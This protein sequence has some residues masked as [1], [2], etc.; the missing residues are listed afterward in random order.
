MIGVRVFYFLKCFCLVPSLTF[1]DLYVF[2]W[3]FDQLIDSSAPDY[4]AQQKIRITNVSSNTTLMGSMSGVYTQDFSTLKTKAGDLNNNSQFLVMNSVVNNPSG[5]NVIEFSATTLKFRTENAIVLYPSGGDHTDDARYTYDSVYELNPVSGE[6]EFTTL[7]ASNEQEKALAEASGFEVVLIE[8]QSGD[9][10]A[11]TSFKSYATNITNEGSVNIETA[12]GLITEQ[13]S[14]PDGT[15]L[16]RKEDDGTV[17]IGL[18]SIVLADEAVSASGTDEVYS[19]SGVLQLGNNG[20]HRTVIKGSLEVP[21]PTIGS[22]AANKSYVD[23]IGA[24]MMAA[25]QVTQTADPN[26]NL[27]IGFGLG[28]LAGENAL[29]L[30]LTGLSNDGSLRY[31]VTATYSDYAD[32]VAVGAGFSWSLR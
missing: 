14:N 4:A 10:A 2:S 29:A 25:T 22:H 17:H 20:Q 32:E 30:G 31:S 3:P 19:S 12:G 1:A 15:S 11:T 21:K 13:L 26:S 28:S 6:L 7:I 24:M 9:F 8:S 23:G 18:N 16:L 27:N 5:P